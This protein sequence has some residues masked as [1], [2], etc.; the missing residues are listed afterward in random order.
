VIHS[1]V[2][3]RPYFMC[4]V[5]ALKVQ[6]PAQCT[7]QGNLLRYLYSKCVLL[8]FSAFVRVLVLPVDELPLQCPWCV[9]LPVPVVRFFLELHMYSR[10][11]LL[12]Y[13]TVQK[14]KKM[15]DTNHKRTNLRRLY[16][17]ENRPW[18]V[19]GRRCFLCT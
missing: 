8:A 16:Q 6:V 5:R 2:G 9:P 17:M 19:R 14:Y 3:A 10:S 7:V 13:Y 12:Y 11:V 1:S 15:A 18:F 4:F